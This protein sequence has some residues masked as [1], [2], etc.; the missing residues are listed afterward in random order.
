MPAQPDLQFRTTVG[1]VLNNDAAKEL[2]GTWKLVWGPVVYADA[3]VGAKTSVNS[4]F[5]AVPAAHPHSGICSARRGFQFKARG[6]AGA[7]S[8]IIRI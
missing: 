3:F 1:N 5:I 2:I 6:L 4:M 8:G 7:L